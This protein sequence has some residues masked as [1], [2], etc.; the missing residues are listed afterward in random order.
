MNPEDLPLR[1]IHLPMPVDWWPPAPGW[2]LLAVLMLVVVGFLVW[3]WRRQQ[4]DELALDLALH[5]LERLQGQYGANSKDLLRELSVLLRR[6]AISQYGRERVSGLTGAAWVRFL[7]EKAGRTLF[8]DKFAHLLTE[9]PYRPES[10]AE[11]AALLQAVRLWLK[12]QRGASH[13]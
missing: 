5:E 4:H 11:T 8:G 13:V 9:L 1:D 10:Q 2:W 6:A 12:L 7:D 3:R